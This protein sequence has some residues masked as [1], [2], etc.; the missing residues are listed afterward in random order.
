MAT[1]TPCRHGCRPRCCESQGPESLCSQLSEVL[2]HVFSL[3]LQR[4]P[5]VWK[6]SCLVPVP[7]M[8]HPIDP[9]DYRPVA[10]TSHIIKTLVGLILEQ[11]QPIVHPFVWHSWLA[12]LAEK[13][14]EMQ[15]DAP[16]VSWM[17]DD[18]PGRPQPTVLYVTETCH[19]QRFPD[20]SAG[21]GCITERQCMA[22]IYNFVTWRETIY[23]SV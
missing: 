10:L 19:L 22:V 13:L 3:S 12:L 16:L 15:V 14:T 1:E 18:L 5:V 21:V 8:R 11:L 2:H 6:T 23:S 9:K 7:N 17:V 20:D 4:D